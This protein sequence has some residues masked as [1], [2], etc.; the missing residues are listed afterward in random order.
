M[1]IEHRSG[2]ARLDTAVIH[3]E[4][5]GE[6]PPV[7]F[8]SG[9]FGDAGGWQTVGELLAESYTVISYDRRGNSRSPSPAGWSVTSLDE[10]ADDAAGLLEFLET[11]PTAIW[12]N[13]LGGAIGLTAALR[14]PDL[15]TLAVLHEP[16]LAS[17]LAEPTTAT[18]PII[19][20]TA[21]F[22]ATDDLVGAAAALMRLVCGSDTYEALPVPVRDRMLGNAQTLFGL[23]IPG[24]SEFPVADITPAIP[25]T[26]AAGAES[27]S[28][29]TAGAHRLA[30]LLSVDVR[31]IPGAHV[32]QITHPEAVADTLRT[33][34]DAPSDPP[35]HAGDE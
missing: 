12:A 7:L 18:G 35:G 28:F 19:E 17:L 27:P 10:Q 26:I 32:P 34:I 21:P 23:E 8:V 4:I 25:V 6:G 2:E 31:E 33:V 30:E 29:L 13:S 1:T 11:G 5:R 9:A 20:A 14:R 24:L 3:Y 15:V 16:F 22:L